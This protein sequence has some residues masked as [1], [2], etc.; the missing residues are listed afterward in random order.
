[1][2]ELVRDVQSYGDELRKKRKRMKEVEARTASMVEQF[3]AVK[4]QLQRSRD[5]Y[6][7]LAADAERYNNSGS[8]GGGGGSSDK[9]ISS[10]PLQQS[11]SAS[12]STNF[13][14]AMM[15][16]GFGGGQKVEKKLQQAAEEYKQAIEKYNMTR[17]DYIQLFKSSCHSFQTYEEAHVMQMSKFVS[18]YTQHLEQLNEARGQVRADLKQKLD[19]V[20]TVDGLIQQFL[21]Q[22]GTGHELPEL[23][24]FVDYSGDVAAASTMAASSSS[25]D[26]GS[27][28]TLT[29]TMS[30]K[31]QHLN[32]STRKVSHQQAVKIT[33]ITL[34][35]AAYFFSSSLQYLLWVW[36]IFK[37]FTFSI[38]IFF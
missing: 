27:S 31:K 34:I 20:Y 28:T 16:A 6:M 30:N 12:S 15:T 19:N 33:K 29:A 10:A 2:L 7:S 35:S 38:R 24:E 14:L 26:G 5:A 21:A 37:Q 13:P 18:A 25:M 17:E 32:G 11:H 1:M 36:A 22:K 8:G 3:R 4:S 23:G 9:Q